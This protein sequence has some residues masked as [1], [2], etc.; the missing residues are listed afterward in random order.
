MSKIE[1]IEENRDKVEEKTKVPCPYWLEMIPYTITFVALTYISYTFI[2]K[3]PME[4]K[5]P[6]FCKAFAIGCVV[7]WCYLLWERWYYYGPNGFYEI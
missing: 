7:Q 4:W 5:Y 3:Q 1:D 2:D 6:S